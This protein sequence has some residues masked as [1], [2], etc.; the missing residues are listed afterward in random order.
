MI[1]S[2]AIS[3]R[4]KTA[5]A[6]AEAVDA[7]GDHLG[8]AADM[9]VAFF[10]SDHAA[11]CDRAAEE[12]AVRLGTNNV[13]GC[14]GES[15]VGRGRE[16]EASS[17]VSVWAGRIPGL[18]T[19][20]MHLR[21]ERTAE[22]GTIV[23]WPDSLPETWPSGSFLIVLG[24]PFSFPADAMLE[25]LNDDRP[26][27]PVVGGM[28]SSAS[29]PGENRLLLGSQAHDEGAVALLAHG[30]RLTT[31]VSQGCRPIGRP[32]V[33]TKAEQNVIHELGGRAALLQL[34]EIFDQLP[35]HEQALVQR[36]LHVG[37]VI[38]E[39]QDHF[40]QGDFLI[41]NV[42][43]I[44]PGRGSVAIGDFV[45]PGQTV[46]FHIRD[47]KTADDEFRQM[48]ARV[49]MDSPTAHGGRSAGLPSGCANCAAL[50]FTCNGRGTRLFSQ[51]DHDAG[52]IQQA[53]GDIPLAGFFAAGEMGP[54]GGKNFLHGFTASVAILDGGEPA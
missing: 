13:L 32:L 48:L 20:P 42:I 11:N 15:I 2:S 23:G 39:Y 38:S 31:V 10:S 7:I 34:K 19:W 9:V 45:R 30:P 41:R 40:E 6:V 53:L 21:F 50:L 8:G 47:E 22:G 52:A 14:T 49:R 3:T 5:E 25:R 24:D 43:G 17:A 44:D 35:N 28:A 51:P 37:R 36:G 12:L 1:F 54:V 16:I 46:Q 29:A 26:A 33:I 4:S 27:T 18:Q